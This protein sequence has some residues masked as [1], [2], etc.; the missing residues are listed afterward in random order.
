MQ[1][2][3]DT[4]PRRPVTRSMDGFVTARQTPLAPQQAPPRPTT[5]YKPQQ[6]Q[7]ASKQPLWKRAAIS[8]GHVV[9]FVSVL[10][11]V[12]LIQS[13][14]IG[15]LVIILYGLIVFFLKL[16]SRKTFFLVLGCISVVTFAS[17]RSD[18]MLANT[19]AMYAFFLLIIATLSLAREVRS[20][21]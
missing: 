1:Q 21:I 2:D 17:V 9:L 11:G 6:A 7:K 15:Q 8:I 20:E 4:Y 12:F 14:L 13:A 5:Q 10:V 19:F 18:I 3:S 16:S